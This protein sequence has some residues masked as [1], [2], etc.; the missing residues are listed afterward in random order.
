MILVSVVEPTH[1][2]CFLP[3]LSCTLSLLGAL[4]RHLVYIVQKEHRCDR[5]SSLKVEQKLK[6]LLLS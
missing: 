6:R 2:S 4:G 3:Y 5:L 1:V